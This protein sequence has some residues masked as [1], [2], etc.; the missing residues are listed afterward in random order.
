M[1]KIDLIKEIHHYLAPELQLVNQTIINSLTSDEELIQVITNHLAQAGGKRI[2]PILT[3]LTAKLT[4]GATEEAIKL[5]A[6]VEFIHM[7]TLLHDDVVDGSKMRRFLPTANLLWGSKASILVGDF[8]FSQ[9][10]K[11][12]VATESLQALRILSK[13][14]SLIAEGEVKQLAQL[15]QKQLITEADYLKIIQAKTAELFAA[16]CSVGAIINQ[17]ASADKNDLQIIKLLQKFGFH[18]G[19]IFQI[20]D[21]N[22]DYFGTKQRAGKN[23]GDDFFEGK[24]TLPIIMLLQ[25]AT[26][27]DKLTINQLLAKK[28]KKQADFTLICSY[29]AKYNIQAEAALYLTNLRQETLLTLSSLKLDHTTKQA[30]YFLTQLVD[31]AVNRTY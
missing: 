4:G 21:D 6:A 19:S 26:S 30:S 11:L 23:I 7:A 20:A 14:A 22:L 2:R 10:F 9:A 8:L 15:E 3:I 17:T 28:D 13:A 1:S 24:I 5:A 25:Q 12:I 18:L 31:F 27:P 29:L 16:A